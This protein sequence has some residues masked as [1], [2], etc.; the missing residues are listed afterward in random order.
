MKNK[1]AGWLWLAR[2]W[3]PQAQTATDTVLHN[4]GTFTNGANPC[5]TLF[6][7]SAGNL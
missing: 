4:L 7:D 3:T 5:G 6:R 1:L 2:A